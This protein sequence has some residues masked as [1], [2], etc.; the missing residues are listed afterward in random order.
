MHAGTYTKHS[1][2]INAVLG[3]NTPFLLSFL[4]R[5]S[6][7]GIVKE[8]DPCEFFSSLVAEVA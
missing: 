4:Q 6:K 2:A 7:Q 1:R 5:S 8:N 3:Q